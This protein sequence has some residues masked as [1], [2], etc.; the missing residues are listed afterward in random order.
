LQDWKNLNVGF[1]VRYYYL[2]LGTDKLISFMGLQDLRG[3]DF[4][5][6]LKFNLFKGKCSKK[7]VLN[8]N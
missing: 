7:R 1:S 2:T 5:A 4:Y 3:F 6:S 8:C